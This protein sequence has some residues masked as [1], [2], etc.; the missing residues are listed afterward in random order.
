M[1]VPMNPSP[2]DSSSAL[3]RPRLYERIVQRIHTLVVD[4]GLGPGDRL[5]TERELAALLGVSRAS[6]SQALVALEVV[7]FVDVRHGDGIFLTSRA[8]TP[9]IIDEF[10]AHRDRLPAIIEARV[11]LE[12][13]LAR[14][15]AERR[16]EADLLALNAALEIMEA[17]VGSGHR[18][19]DGDERFHAAIAA[20]G[21]SE[22]LARF[23]AEISGLVRETRLESLGQPGRGKRSLQDHRR[24]VDAIA[25]GDPQGA[26]RLMGE[27]LSS[28]ANVALL[29]RKTG[30]VT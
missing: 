12:V 26:A 10:R 9:S 15:A 20:A 25:D 22:L 19:S 23:M 5:P 16:T 28:V 8:Q 24:I 21:H 18:G 11:A 29:G 30:R 3:T 27:H 2:T 13:P 6:V 17:E 7:G 14:L 4:D 1:L